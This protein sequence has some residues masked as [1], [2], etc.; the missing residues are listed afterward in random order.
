MNLTVAPLITSPLLIPVALQ[1]QPTNVPGLVA[2]GNVQDVATN[3]SYTF[4]NAIDG[5]G[6]GS[7]AI[8]DAATGAFTY[9]PPFASF[10]GLVQISY[11]V[12][13]G[14]NMAT[15]T[16]S[17]NVEQTIQPKNDGPIVAVAGKPLTIS[18]VDLLA[19]DVAAPNGLKLSI[20]SVGNATNGTVVLN[21][22]G[23]V[24]FTPIAKGTAT[25]TY[26]DTDADSD[27]S[28]VATV[29]LDVK[30]GPDVRWVTPAAIV[31]GTPLGSAQLNATASV[32]GTF[33]YGPAAGTIL[34]AGSGQTLVVEFTPMDTADYADA[35]VK[36]QINVLQATP[37]I[38]WSNPGTIVKGTPLSTAQLDATASVPGTFS[39][40]PGAGTV[41]GTGNGQTLTAIFTPFDSVDYTAGYATT[42]INVQPAAPPG[43][44]VGT[45]SFS[46]RVKHNVGGAI[47]TLRTTLSKLKTTYYSAL[48]NWGDG[49]VQKGKLAKSGTHGFKVNATHKYSASGTYDATV[50]ISDPHGDSVT[51]NFVVS[52]H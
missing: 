39:Y 40:I 29:N 47:A 50:T 7:V 41:L 30:L 3:P 37:F 22:N 33:Q 49:A 9:T 45:R 18:A 43:L 28:T 1:T 46:G 20:G 25:F 36:V 6:D 24:T 38:Y 10:F 11:T 5:P 32:P 34:N 12:T 26:I 44:T 31:Y 42:T 15:G 21:A 52:V 4:S 23:S 35:V 16:V 19:N 51:E 27:A 48:I 2:S 14:T 8:T 13:D 17:I